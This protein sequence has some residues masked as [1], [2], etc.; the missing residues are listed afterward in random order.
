MLINNEAFNLLL[1]TTHFFFFFIISFN[2][3]QQGPITTRT[4]FRFFLEGA[5]TTQKCTTKHNNT[6]ATICS[7]PD[8]TEPDTDCKQGLLIAAFIYSVVY[9]TNTLGEWWYKVRNT[10]SI[11]NACFVC[12]K[13][14]D[15][16]SQNAH[17]QPREHTEVAT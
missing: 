4:H 6:S 17:S 5:K 10:G 2:T 14:N 8:A 1:H 12:W 11:R 9:A 3:Q 7:T 13:S 15:S 16:L